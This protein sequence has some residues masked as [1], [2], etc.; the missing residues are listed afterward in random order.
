MIRQE[1]G[2][3][4]GRQ[5]SNG[6]EGQRQ[7]GGAQAGRAQTPSASAAERSGDPLTTSQEEWRWPAAALGRLV[8][9]RGFSRAAGC[10]LLLSQ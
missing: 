8:C 2:G 4:K 10:L 9:A 6:K 3:E 1:D 5:E 7:E